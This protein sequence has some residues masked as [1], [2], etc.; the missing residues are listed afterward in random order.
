MMQD[1]LT[2]I[3]ALL[4]ASLLLTACQTYD[5]SVADKR[6]RPNV[7]LIVSDDMGYTDLGAFGG[8]DIATPNLDRLAFGGLRLTN[9]HA[10]PSCAPTRAMLM[11][12]TG[13]HEAG[14]GTQLQKP[15][16]DGEKYY[17][18][19]LHPRIA[20]LPEVLQAS[21]Y[22]TVMSGKWHLGRGDK[23]DSTLPGR[24]GF[25]R[26]FALLN[27][28]DGHLHSVFEDPA[29]YSEDGVRLDAPPRDYYSTTL[30]TDKLIDQLDSVGDKPF[31]ALF[32]PTAPHWPLQAPPDWVDKYRGHYD[33]GF[34]VLCAARM[35]GAREHAVLPKRI[36]SDHCPKE[37]LPWD[38]LD[39]Q[40][41]A[42]YR[43]VM[44]VHAAMVEHLDSEVGRIVEYLEKKGELDNT[45]I[46][47]LNDNGPQ[48]GALSPRYQGKLT[49]R[50]RD[51]RLENIG[52]AWSW[53]NIGQGWADAISA[54][55]RGSKAS[56]YEGGI[57]VPAFVWHSQ[58]SRSGDRDDQLLTAMDVMPTV[59]DLANVN[60]PDGSFAG[61][62]VLSMRGKSFAPIFKSGEISVH[63][64]DEPIVLDSAGRS[65]VMKGNW[66]IVRDLIG[67]WELYHTAADPG[68][69]NDLSATHV[70]KL[71]EL[72]ADFDQQARTSNYIRRRVP[73]DSP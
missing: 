29:Q 32:A 7:L 67:D 31:F 64:A 37:E 10:A 44:E 72:V 25:D 34:D 55:Y 60:A 59:L 43:R 8:G 40:K 2:A 3:P 11:S 13:N 1:N 69:K 16:Y 5:T 63:S 57:R 62:D 54:P 28:A 42:Q 68:E 66:K 18:R 49:R 23:T 50:T 36:D 45:W 35:R 73:S 39:D 61:R 56:Q 4:F 58:T 52:K 41:R 30:F 24:R 53:T 48:G 21:G 47:Y 20:A 65:V 15:E 9:F 33:Q 6:S 46:I 14:L 70:E 17:E 71:A 22:Y 51:N 38:E 19:Y 27:G 12:G 26:A